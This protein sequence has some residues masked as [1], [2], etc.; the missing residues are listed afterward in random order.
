MRY[1][2]LAKDVGRMKMDG[3]RFFLW[4]LVLCAA[5]AADAE[6]RVYEPRESGPVRIS[7][8]PD[9]MLHDF[10]GGG[11]P[12]TS[13][14]GKA[15]PT[16]EVE[17]GGAPFGGN[18]L[19]VSMPATGQRGGHGVNV[20]LP[21]PGDLRDWSG[22][23]RLELWLLTPKGGALDRGGEGGIG[24]YRIIAHVQDDSGRWAA[25]GMMVRPYLGG[26]WQ[27][28]P[29]DLDNPRWF[30]KAE[31]RWVSPNWKSVSRLRL[32]IPAHSQY[33]VDI[34]LADIGLR[35]T[36]PKGPTALIQARKAGFLTVPGAE[37]PIQLVADRL[38]EGQEADVKVEV[39]DF[40]GRPVFARSETFTGK[41][42]PVEKE[43]AF[44]VARPGFYEIRAELST[45]GKPVFRSYRGLACLPPLS[46]EQ[47]AARAGSIFGIWPGA[48][49][50]LGACY[51]RK[52]LGEPD[53]PEITAAKIARGEYV[54]TIPSYPSNGH[55]GIC[56]VTGPRHIWKKDYF[57]TP[58]TP[59]QWSAYAKFLETA[60]RMAAAPAPDGRFPY[61][62][63]TPDKLL[64]RDNVSY[65]GG[66]PF[67]YYEVINEPNA[68]YWGPME[69]LVDYH[70][71][72]YE[73]VK[74][75]DPKAKIGG[76]TPYNIDVDYIEKFLAAGGD[77]WVDAIIVHGYHEEQDFETRL[78]A[79]KAMLARRGLA[80]K[81][82]I[83]TEI[84]RNIP[85]STPEQQAYGLVRAYVIAMAEG[86]RIMIWHSYGGII[87]RPGDRPIDNRDA[88]F[89]IM[90]PDNTP[91]PAFV[92]YG[93]MTRMLLGATAVGEAAG[94]P[95]SC[96]G[97]EFRQPGGGRLL[98]LWRKAPGAET[99]KLP[100]GGWITLTDIMG[101]SRP[102]KR[103]ADGATNVEASENPVYIGEK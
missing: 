11:R 67:P 36:A 91:N 101:V 31:K 75:G 90:R 46:A 100:E 28:V 81:E 79:L 54:G 98:V 56:W 19:L 97:F 5:R 10:T 47:R 103:A 102:I 40:W 33:A 38:P 13:V 62:R 59:E 27:P 51:V 4:A 87:A 58:G 23:N 29:V 14:F 45:D 18:T 53:S 16:V 39:S 69:K 66:R 95:E 50:V 61:Y 9:K 15:E 83:I 32:E 73:A 85:S 65:P 49:D 7:S 3:R 1:V 57:D 94:L 52:A 70:R 2:F 26:V 63:E 37:F 12:Q 17:P 68:H 21:M 84:G 55:L 30:C 86:V 89:N 20:D 35:Q 8:A 99:V 82:I 96:R 77:K 64:Y 41:S 78:R 44:P 71:L 72:V 22:N 24:G 92:A 80:E 93:V 43:I 74:R 48:E 25:R 76:P 34:R 6:P 88:D 60:A 42:G